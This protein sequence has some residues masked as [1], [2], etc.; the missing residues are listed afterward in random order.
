[1]RDNKKHTLKQQFFQRVFYNIHLKISGTKT[2][3][4]IEF[5][6][7]ASRETFLEALFL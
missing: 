2:L 4:P 3:Q 6:A 7:F 1:M 5:T